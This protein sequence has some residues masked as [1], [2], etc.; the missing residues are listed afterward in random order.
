MVVDG[1]YHKYLFAF[2]IWYMP[3]DNTVYAGFNPPLTECKNG[4][5]QGGT[6]RF[7]PVQR[8]SSQCSFATIK[9]DNIE[10][11]YIVCPFLKLFSLKK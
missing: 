1:E 8:I 9:I 6:S 2:V 11:R 10:E 4:V 5:I 3:S 7:P